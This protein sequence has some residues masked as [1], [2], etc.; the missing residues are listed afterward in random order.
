MSDVRTTENTLQHTANSL[1]DCTGYAQTALVGVGLREDL[2]EL[3]EG[4]LLLLLHVAHEREVR[5]RGRRLDLQAG[6]AARS[7][8][9]LC[10]AGSARRLFSWG[11]A[12]SSPS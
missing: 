2:R 11:K 6:M 7:R 8:L 5:R 1:E 3:V 12:G 4:V 9:H 10:E